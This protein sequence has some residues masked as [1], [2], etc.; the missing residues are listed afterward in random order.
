MQ[1]AE[2]GVTLQVGE[3]LL[4]HMSS[5]R[6]ES[7]HACAQAL[8]AL[9]GMAAQGLCAPTPAWASQAMSA[10][11]DLWAP[12]GHAPARAAL[13]A[14]LA[15]N[16][17]LLQVRTA[18]SWLAGWHAGSGNWQCGG[19]EYL[20]GCMVFVAAWHAKYECGAL[21]ALSMHAHLH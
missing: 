18:C 21:P 5:G 10:L 16:L 13:L 1:S 4:G 19:H 3:Y 6:P 9:A 11:V 12:D 7:S 17:H 14:L 8:L 15:S 2:N 20:H